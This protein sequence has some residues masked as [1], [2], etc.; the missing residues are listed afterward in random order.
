MKPKTKISKKK[1]TNQKP[2]HDNNKTKTL[3]GKSKA[4]STSKIRK[5]IPTI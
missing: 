5:R 1:I 2:S 3:Q 4:I